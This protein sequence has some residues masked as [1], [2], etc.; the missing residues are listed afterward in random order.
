MRH[1]VHSCVR[2]L[3]GAMAAKPPIREGGAASFAGGQAAVACHL[4]PSTFAS[5]RGCAGASG[6][7]AYGR[8]HAG[9]GEHVA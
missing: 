4:A 6:G 1:N 9:A 7:G 3:W 5:D 2:S 8:A